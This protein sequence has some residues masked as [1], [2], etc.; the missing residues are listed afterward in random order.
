MRTPYR[1]TYN[2]QFVANLIR[3]FY[4]GVIMKDASP[5]I[6]LNDRALGVFQYIVESYM[7]D[8][9]WVGSRQLEPVFKCSAA[10]IRNVMADLEEM[11]LLRS[12]HVSAGRVPTETGLRYFVDGVLEVG[13]LSKVER[14]ALEEDFKDK[15][16]SIDS[17]FENAS[18]ALSGLSQSAGL[19]V[20]PKQANKTIHHVEFI[21]LAPQQSLVVLV[22]QDGSI[23]NRMIELPA[24]ITPET[25]RQAGSFLSERLYGHT[26]GNMK[27]LI[28][29]EISERQNEMDTLM[30]TVVQKGLARKLEDGKLI[31]SGT[32][33]LISD[34]KQTEELE[35]LQKLYDQLEE[36]E[37]VSR[38]LDASSEAE[39]VK[40]YIGS[41]NSIFAGTGHSLILSPYKNEQD[42]VVGAIGV[43]GP[44]HLNYAKM[45]PSVNYMAEILSQHIRR[46]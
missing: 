13:T 33:K 19:V 34:S 23:E 10:T 14:A 37:T 16:Q 21:S 6:D 8:G 40:I 41:E 17:I 38:L 18:K 12:P 15:D 4:T 26:I 27:T 24:G 9:K 11:G 39:G 22:A 29:Q 42:N 1:V 35:A 3:A 20:A 31:V 46:L 28:E 5:L 30:T 25:L 32:S 44:K 36:K 45:I 43:I 2:C 7:K